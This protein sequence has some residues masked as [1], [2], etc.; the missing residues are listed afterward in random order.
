MRLHVSIR[1]PWKWLT[2]PEYI[3]VQLELRVS[4]VH[5]HI[6]HVQALHVVAIVLWRC[7][8]GRSVLMRSEVVGTD[9]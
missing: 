4:A 5:A 3:N 1:M 6:G 9:F 2:Y 7:D 8:W